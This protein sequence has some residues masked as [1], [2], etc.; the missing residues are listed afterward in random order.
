M[1]STLGILASDRPQ[2]LAAALTTFG[3]SDRL[4][5][6]TASS[7]FNGSVPNNGLDSDNL[8]AMAIGE[9]QQIADF[10]VAQSSDS[11]SYWAN[12]R[13]ASGTFPDRQQSNS[14]AMTA[15]TDPLTGTRT[16]N[17]LNLSDPGNSLAT[18]RNIG[19]V[20]NSSVNLNDF[21]GVDDNDDYYRFTINS[22]SDL[23]L[24]MNAV[25]GAGIELIQDKN[26]NGK[27]D[28]GELLGSDYASAG[29]SGEI[30]LF[31][32][33][34]GDYYVG[35][36]SYS[37]YKNYNLDIT[38]TPAT[39][40]SSNYGY[41]LVDANAAVAR[42]FN[43]PVKFPEVPNL[44]RN[45]WARDMVNAPEVW[46]GGITGNGIV[47]AVVD[48]GVDYTHLD[49]DANIWQNAGEIPNNGIDDDRNGYVDDIR[50]WDFV[51]GD[52]NP[53]DEKFLR[54]GQL[55]GHGTHVAGAIAAERNGFHITGV[56]PDAKIMPVRVLPTVGFGNSIN[57]AAG[58]R[59]AADNGANVINYSAGGWFPSRE[60]D[61]AIKYATDKG[62]VVVMSAGND[63]LS[64]PDY[65][66]RNA[67]S[68]GIAV[69]AVDRNSKMADFSN[70][71]GSKP[72]DY[73]LAP[74]V[75]ILSATPNNTYK[76]YE[77]T[78][79]AAPHVAG[80]AALVLNANPN[81]TPAQVEQILTSTANSNGIIA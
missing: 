2:Q 6:F 64:Q 36:Y 67:H 35:V 55:F 3:N 66:A 60:I 53:M 16:A 19:V 43:S 65:P 80:V 32:L 72:L 11:L 58:I 54:N 57:V 48:T 30:N 42:A 77:G 59:Y 12:D 69:G 26:R 5:F 63:G 44:G 47:V 78:S 27:A 62:V 81:L 51:S 24:R 61:D 79:M 10:V 29:A 15:G 9:Q 7:Q 23:S 25:N 14:D 8:T 4:N 68:F 52:N 70:R 38:A 20:E 74:G 71:A 37:G 21:V 46:Q 73:V 22:N 13:A 56:A 33:T 75:D 39:G 34:P 50:G 45:D 41:G 40:L 1:E 31:G 18:A 49:L 28:S 17:Q 76:T